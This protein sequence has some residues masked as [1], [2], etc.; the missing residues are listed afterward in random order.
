MLSRVARA[1]WISCGKFQYLSPSTK[2]PIFN[3]G[4][5]TIFQST[6]HRIVLPVRQIRDAKTIPDKKIK[7]IASIFPTTDSL[8]STDGATTPEQN[9][10]TRL[11]TKW[12]KF[13]RIYMTLSKWYLTRKEQNY[14]I[15]FDHVNNLKYFSV[16]VAM[17][18]DAG[19]CL[20]PVMFDQKI[21]V[22]ATI[23]TILCS[24][25]ANTFNQVSSNYH[26]TN[27]SL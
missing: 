13:P 14:V 25:S 19:Y 2:L 16:F 9:D 10:W 8:S 22:L 5:N 1:G 15:N 24:C 6:P 3:Y 21:F 26:Y 23:G 17:T 7:E 27:I 18:A 20:A 12:H 4:H 11:E